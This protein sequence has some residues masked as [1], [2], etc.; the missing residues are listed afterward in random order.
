[1]T[2]RRNRSDDPAQLNALVELAQR[3]HRAGRLAQAAAAYRRILAIR[4]DVGEVHND[5]GIVFAQQ[6]DLAAATTCF[7]QAIALR[8]K[9]ADAFFNLGN[10]LQNLGRFGEAVQR[11]EQAI[12]LRPDY[13][14]RLQPIWESP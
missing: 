9:L 4:P 10:V 5:L 7:L 3:E 12:A 13:D 2:S 1:M 14:R 11:Y 8:P 6:G